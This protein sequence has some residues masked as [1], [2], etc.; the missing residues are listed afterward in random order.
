MTLPDPIAKPRLAVHGT[1][2]KALTIPSPED[3]KGCLAQSRRLF[4]HCVEHW[5]ESSGRAVDDS[6]Y[7]GG[8][9]FSIQ[10][11]VTLSLVFVA[12]GRAL[13]QFALKISNDLCGI[14]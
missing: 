2:M 14:G 10:R 1:K 11:L 13:V 12:L 6:Q 3:A 7:L 4:Q 8:R 9:G 5:R